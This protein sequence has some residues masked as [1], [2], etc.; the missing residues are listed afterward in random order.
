[1]RL[2]L[3]S[4]R[5]RELQ[6]AK[7]IVMTLVMGMKSLLY[8]LSSFGNTTLQRNPLPPGMV[9]SPSFGLREEE[10]EARF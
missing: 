7:T 8:S 1:M 4:D 9:P 2:Q 5:A 10:L 3:V 6:D